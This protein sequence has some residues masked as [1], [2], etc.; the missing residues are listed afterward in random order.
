VG[1]TLPA[2]NVGTP[3]RPLYRVSRDNIRTWMKEREAGPKPPLRKGRFKKST[4]TPK[5][6]PPSPHFPQSRRGPASPASSYGLSP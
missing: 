3:D 1:G 4:P 2:S 5:P 6:A